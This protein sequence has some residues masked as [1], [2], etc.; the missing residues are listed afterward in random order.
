[1][2]QAGS[3]RTCRVCPSPPKRQMSGELV[4]PCCFPYTATRSRCLRARSSAGQS[5]GLIIRWS[6]VRIQPGPRMSPTGT[7][8]EPSPPWRAAASRA[9]PLLMLAKVQYRERVRIYARPN[10]GSPSV[11]S[12]TVAPRKSNV[13]HCDT[14][15]APLQFR[16][17]G[18][19]VG[20]RLRR[21]SRPAAGRAKGDWVRAVRLLRRA[22]ADG[23]AA[24]RG[25][26]HLEA[27]AAVH[28]PFF[29]G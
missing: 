12:L 20:P 15:Q 2:A 19:S 3:L 1:M 22:D 26:F 6:L 27:R 14:A 8:G 18:H 10:A 11:H 9:P 4:T 17:V 13:T 7:S 23:V 21:L 16:S 28:R 29:A 5:G 24:G 25:Q